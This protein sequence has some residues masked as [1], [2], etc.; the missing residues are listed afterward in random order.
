MHINHHRGE[1]RRTAWRNRT[2]RH[3]RARIGRWNRA[4]SRR[5]RGA[6]SNVLRAAKAHDRIDLDLQFPQ[7]NEIDNLWNYD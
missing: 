2:F 3:W 7:Q 6:C 5:Y 4:A 1:T